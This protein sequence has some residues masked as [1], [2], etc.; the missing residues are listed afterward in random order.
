MLK[1]AKH[2]VDGNTAIVLDTKQFLFV[3]PTKID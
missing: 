1:I 2:I 3:G